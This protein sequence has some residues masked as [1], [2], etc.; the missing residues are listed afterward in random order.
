MQQ[1][2]VNSMQTK[3]RTYIKIHLQSLCQELKK[4]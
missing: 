1:R 3:D 2:D 4:Y